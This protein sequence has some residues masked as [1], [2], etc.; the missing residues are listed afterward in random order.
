MTSSVRRAV[1]LYLLAV[2]AGAALGVAVD[3]TLAQGR[4]PD[5]R[6][7]PRAMREHFYEELAVTPAQR[8]QLDSI[9][10]ARPAAYPALMSP[11]RP[12]QDSIAAAAR[13]RLVAVLT[14][15]QRAKYETME[16][17]RQAR[18]RRPRP[19]SR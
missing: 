13:A 15:E 5:W 11:L 18:A 1:L 9:F 4:R 17:E 16:R 19:E 6:G 3:R 12:Q 8:A 2:G 14:P 7:N 10:D